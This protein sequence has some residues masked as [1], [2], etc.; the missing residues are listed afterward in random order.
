MRRAAGDAAL[1]MGTAKELLES[2]A[3]Y[4]LEELDVPIRSNADFG[5]LLHFARE[6]LGLLPQ[7]VGESAPAA[8]AV[9][10]VFDGLWRVAKAV[11][12]LRNLEGTG[13][14]R[15]RL[16]GVTPETARA[17]VRAVAPMCELM[18]ETLDASLGRTAKSA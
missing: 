17:V 12:D 2:T 1:L 5:E 15:T 7:Q 8:R 18:L 3:R 13:H 14:G 4:V 10:E 9:R 11:N 6:R 16:P